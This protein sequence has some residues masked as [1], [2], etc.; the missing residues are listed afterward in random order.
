MQKTVIHK[1]SEYLFFSLIL[2]IPFIDFIKFNDY[3]YFHLEIIL[4]SMGL[5]AGGMV[6]AWFYHRTNATVKLLIFAI[7]VT[8]A[9]SFLPG[10]QSLLFL[11]SAFVVTL[12]LAMLLA[13]V[14][15]KIVSLFAVVF[16]AAI[17]L[18]PVKTVMADIKQWQLPTTHNNKLPPI[19][20]LILD[21]HAGIDSLPTNTA[22]QQTFKQQLQDFYLHAGFKLFT[23]AY[24]HYP[25]TYNSISNLLNFTASVKDN[26]YFVSDDNR[27][28][29]Q[30]DFFKLLA[31]RGYQIRV[32]QP[33]YIDY[34]QPDGVKVNSCY[35][36]SSSSIKNI[37]EV[38]LP[39]NERMLFIL[40]SYLLQSKM[41]HVAMD[42]YQFRLRPW[43]VMKGLNA[44]QW[45]WYQA[46]VSALSIPDTFKQ[47]RSAVVQSPQGTVFFAHL[48]APHAPYVYD[49][50]CNVVPDI[51]RWE[52]PRG[53]EPLI[54]S[55]ATRIAR[56][57]QY[58]GQIGCVE[59]QLQMLFTT[60]QQAG[61]YDKAI[62]IVHADHGS[63]ISVHRPYIGDQQN[64]IFNQ[65]DFYDYYNAL[66]AVKMP[67][68]A[69]TE[70]NQL[71]DLQTLLVQ[72]TEKITGQKINYSAPVPFV[73]LHAKDAGDMLQ[74][75]KVA[76]FK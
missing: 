18:M 4:M 21:E 57:N 43:L 35:T 65:Q 15:E 10:L 7:T 36:Y 73:Y 32:Y 1:I 71:I 3:G 39:L 5:I 13:G 46:R 16:L 20:Y 60:M 12:A 49:A 67:G 14:L 30:N 51:N 62:I 47:L 8:C 17:I 27:V 6:L 61:I 50:N 44:P 59:K 40:K 25:T 29:K 31:A 55:P 63:R 11:A 56:Y 33:T 72:I 54:N 22:P 26:Y 58:E 42:R 34:C 24:S 37:A 75:R 74:Q 69:A 48:L 38:G 70:N 52:V 68:V 76:E 66:F 28:L 53:P 9:V 64:L 45:N 23:A 19:I 2:L 41:Y